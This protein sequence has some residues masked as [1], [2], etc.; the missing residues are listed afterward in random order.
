MQVF[1]NTRQWSNSVKKKTEAN[2]QSKET[3]VG[4]TCVYVTF[5][6]WTLPK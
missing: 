3:T 4:K 1:K 5:C 6:L 2:I